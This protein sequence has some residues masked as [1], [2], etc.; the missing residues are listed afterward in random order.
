MYPAYSEKGQAGFLR[1]LKNKSNVRREE[2]GLSKSDLAWLNYHNAGE[3]ATV[4][5]RPSLWA[6][7]Q[8]SSRYLL[9][10]FTGEKE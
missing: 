4:E 3:C 2:K 1:I 6:L 7:I 8:N 10:K 5:T 9:M